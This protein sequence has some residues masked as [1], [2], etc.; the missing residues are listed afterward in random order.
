MGGWSRIK[1]GRNEHEASC[2]ETSLLVRFGCD[3]PRP[4]RF[5]GLV[6]GASLTHLGDLV[7]LHQFVQQLGFDPAWRRRCASRNR[8]TGTARPKPPWP[9]C[10]RRPRPRADRDDATPGPQRR[11]PVPQGL[12]GAPT[13][14]PTSAGTLPSPAINTFIVSDALILCQRSRYPIP[15]NPKKNNDAVDPNAVDAQGLPI[16]VFGC[17]RNG[18]ASS[19]LLRN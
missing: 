4:P 16:S 1:P 14:T 3:G 5:G 2:I 11:V 15:G 13:R 18:I 10:T 17:P 9:W 12:V 6:P 19:S 7:L 8:T